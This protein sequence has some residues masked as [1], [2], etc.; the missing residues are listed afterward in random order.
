M[1]RSEHIRALLEEY[2]QQR[3]A[4][5]ADQDARLAE[6]AR[7][8]PEIARLREEQ[9]DL[10]LRTMRQILALDTREARVDAAQRMR[11]RG[12]ANNAEIRRRLA[13]L[14]LPGGL[15]RNALPLSGLP[16]HGLCRRRAVALLRVL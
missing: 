9:A 4:D 3:M 15:S 16:R 12:I 13:A 8:D 5:E 1:T 10:A 6:A 7:R 11:Q 14:G 2:A